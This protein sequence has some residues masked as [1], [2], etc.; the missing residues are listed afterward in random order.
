MRMQA[1]HDFL[2]TSSPISA[3]MMCGSAKRCGSHIGIR[4]NSEPRV[5]SGPPKARGGIDTP[6]SLRGKPR[7]VQCPFHLFLCDQSH[8]LILVT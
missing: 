3:A 5:A 8:F 1:N 4:F 2:I 6:S 7:Q